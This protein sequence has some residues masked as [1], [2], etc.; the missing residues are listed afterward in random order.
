MVLPVAL[1]SLKGKLYSEREMSYTWRMI[2]LTQER[3]SWQMAVDHVLLDQMEDAI[4][5]REKIYP[6]FRVYKF[7]RHAAILGSKQKPTK[8]DEK[9]AQEYGIDITTRLT[10]GGVAYFTPEELHLT[11]IA[12]N[13]LFPDQ[14][15]QRYEAINAAVVDVLK[16][17]GIDAYAKRTSVRVGDDQRLFVSGQAKRFYTLIHHGTLQINFDFE[18]LKRALKA[19][20]E[21]EKS[22]SQKIILLSQLVESS[23]YGNAVRKLEKELPNSLANALCY[24]KYR[25]MPLTEEEL[26]S[27]KHI[28]ETIYDNF[29]Y[30]EKHGTKEAGICQT[31]E[32]DW[33]K[34]DIEVS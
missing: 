31:E 23:D 5:N 18:I 9:I 32:F 20:D 29:E 16:K 21:E 15:P 25:E 7:S 28:Q 30:I 4:K 34:K 33:D 1:K 14:L 6:T 13:N 10:G 22:L 17:I 12:P 27:A 26:L 8:I 11:V 2:P 19:T 3:A 24:G